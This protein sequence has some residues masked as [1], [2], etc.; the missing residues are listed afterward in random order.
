[1]LQQAGAAVHQ[2]LADSLP[3]TRSPANRRGR[4]VLLADALVK[5]PADHREIFV[6]RNIEQIP[7]NEIAVHSNRSPGAARV[8]WTRAMRG[9]GQL[10]EEEE[11]YA[12]PRF[13]SA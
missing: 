7:F 11:S 5:L 6:L 9:S 3:S 8:L 13:L 1:M 10:L 12:E 4:A 2:A